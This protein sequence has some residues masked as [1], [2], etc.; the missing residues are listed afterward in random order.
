MFHIEGE[1]IR[2]GPSGYYEL[3]NFSVSEL[4]IAAF[5]SEDRFTIDIQYI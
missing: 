3:E 4:G 5:G 1:E 2:I